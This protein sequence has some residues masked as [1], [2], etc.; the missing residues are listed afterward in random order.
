MSKCSRRNFRRWVELSKNES[1]RGK[2]DKEDEQNEEGTDGEEA[3]EEDE[4]LL[5]A[6]N[7]LPE[8]RG[9]PNYQPP[10]TPA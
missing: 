9:Q 3:A 10:I 2:Q 6:T 7:G 4:I 1:G 8:P 5:N